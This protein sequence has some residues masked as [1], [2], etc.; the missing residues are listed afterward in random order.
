MKTKPKRRNKH[1]KYIPEVCECCDQDTSYEL[2]LDKGSAMIVY[3]IAKFI[4]KKGINQVHPRKEMEGNGMSSNEVGNLSR[5]RFH[6][7]IAAVPDNPGSYLLTRKGA[8][9]LKNE[10][11]PKIAIIRKA[12]KNYGSHNIGYHL[13][14]EITTTFRQLI[15]E[16]EY[17]TG[18]DYDIVEGR[19]VKEIPVK[20][21]LF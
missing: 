2:G 21:T 6:G 18:I 7:L 17:W 12:T 13:P 9:F 5:P 3:K 4:G 15:Q 8:K 10:V 1:Q 16:E 14:D 19:I 11:V 20:Q